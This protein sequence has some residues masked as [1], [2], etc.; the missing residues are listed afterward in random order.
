MIISERRG[1]DLQLWRQSAAAER[2]RRQP[3]FK[4][5]VDGQ[6]FTDY[7]D[8]AALRRRAAELARETARGETTRDFFQ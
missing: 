3:G 2:A 1:Y 6:M 4:V 5:R 8:D 7:E